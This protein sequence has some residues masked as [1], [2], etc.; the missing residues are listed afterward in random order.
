MKLEENLSQE[1]TICAE[2]LYKDKIKSKM[3]RKKNIN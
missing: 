3:K 2:K 1:I